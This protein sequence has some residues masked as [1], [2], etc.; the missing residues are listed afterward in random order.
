MLVRTM[1]RKLR[2]A[3]GARALWRRS[4]RSSPRPGK[5]VTWRRGTGG[6]DDSMWRYATCETL[7]QCCSS[8]IG[9]RSSSPWP[10]RSR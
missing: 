7:K 2:I 8:W 5:P 10:H 6:P 1:I 3:S 4:P 9:V